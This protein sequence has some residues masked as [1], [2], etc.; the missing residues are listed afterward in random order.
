MRGH[1]GWRAAR[2]AA[3]I[4]KWAER[5]EGQIELVGAKSNRIELI[6]YFSASAHFVLHSSPKV[7]C[8]EPQY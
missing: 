5:G 8:N 7:N 1:L 2:G 3:R 6:E 4:S